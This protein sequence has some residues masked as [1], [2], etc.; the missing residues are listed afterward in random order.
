M[1]VF[2]C[3]FNL[4]LFPQVSYNVPMKDK[5]MKLRVDDVFLAKVDYL[6]EILDYKNRSD[7]V[8]NVVEKEY[9]KERWLPPF[10]FCKYMRN[11]ICTACD[12]LRVKCDGENWVN[13]EQRII[14]D[15]KE[16]EDGR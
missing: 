11:G 5:E 15:R 3:P 8:R 1:G 16:K 13:C 9:R 7:T 4:D 14:K 2:L 10:G 12:I 6:Q